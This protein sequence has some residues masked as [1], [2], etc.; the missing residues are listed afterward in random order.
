MAETGLAV[1]LRPAAEPGELVTAGK[2]QLLA[3]L[4][5]SEQLAVTPVEVLANADVVEAAIVDRAGT[6]AQHLNQALLTYA[7]LEL[8][9][10][11]IR[12][13]AQNGNGLRRGEEASLG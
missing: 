5:G 3:S 9:A 7:R 13:A 2:E 8:W 11:P 6:P 10:A 12:L 1:R 4:A